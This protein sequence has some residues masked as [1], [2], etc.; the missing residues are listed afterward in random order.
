MALD[1][2]FMNKSIIGR[3]WVIKSISEKC[4][5]L[6]EIATKESELV[7]KIAEV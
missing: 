3:K 7:E 4:S 1:S 6:P 2:N 5:T